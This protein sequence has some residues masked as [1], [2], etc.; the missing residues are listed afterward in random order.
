MFKAQTY[1]RH[2]SGTDRQAVFFADASGGDASKR[3]FLAPK[4]RKHLKAALPQARA[5][6]LKGGAMGSAARAA[7]FAKMDRPND[8]RKAKARRN[9][10]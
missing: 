5:A 8:P 3:R 4:R 1:D 9:T 10:K 6:E 2:T 7:E